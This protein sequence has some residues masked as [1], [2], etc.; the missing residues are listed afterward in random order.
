MYLLC[1]LLLITVTPISVSTDF[2]TGFE[3]GIF[4]REQAQIRD[5]YG[6]PEAKAAGPFGNLQEMMGPLKLM[7]GFIKDKNIEHTF[8]SI[9]VFLSSVSPLLAVFTN[10][11]GGDFCSG[12]I[13]GSNGA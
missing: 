2:L 3:S 8:S 9:E 7:T 10:Y 13:F 6:C 12:L 1:A 5:E 4:I 11:E